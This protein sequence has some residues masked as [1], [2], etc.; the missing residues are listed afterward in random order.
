MKTLGKVY[1]G[2]IFVLLYLPILVMI[3]FSFNATKSTAVF[4][5]DY[6]GGRPFGH[7]YA[8]FFKSE[9]AMNALKNSLILA[10]L[11]ALIATVIGTL[12]AIGIHKLRNHYVKN[13]IS[14]ITNIPMMNPDIVTGISLM[15]LFV[16]TFSI[17]KSGKMGFV[18]ILIAHITFNLP[19]VI[20][21]IMPKLHQMD[22]HL[23]EAALDLG[24]TPVQSF[25]KVELPFLFPA[26]IS[27][28]LMSFTL[29]LDDYVISLF[30]GGTFQT[31][32]IYI[33][34]QARKS[35]SPSIYALSTFFLAC[36]LVLLVVMN[37][38]QKKTDHLE[39]PR[40][41]KKK[42]KIKKSIGD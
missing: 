34:A 16:G 30:T 28:A 12:A 19:Y 8:E 24:C 27:G 21:S 22:K 3:F 23:P 6:E 7:W 37:I 10:V 33:F 41:E 36:V 39:T 35:V 14:G 40:K 4:S 31:L 15:L 1:T 17:L 25:F 9:A 5:F 20:L 2:L 13:V 26:I 38:V 42:Y 32:P 18:T 11:S 29:S